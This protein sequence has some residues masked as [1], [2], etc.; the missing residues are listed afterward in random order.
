MGFCMHT[1]MRLA[2][3]VVCGVCYIREHQR[4]TQQE[5]IASNIDNSRKR[6]RARWTWWARYK[7]PSSFIVL[8]DPTHRSSGS[9]NAFPCAGWRGRWSN[10]DSWMSNRRPFVFQSVT[11]TVAVSQGGQP[12][13]PSLVLYG[14]LPRF[15]LSQNRPRSGSDVPRSTGL[16]I[17]CSTA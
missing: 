9:R 5:K 13:P 7:C 2:L 11:P 1:H 14:R 3:Y 12:C 10:N 8:S 16:G 15:S 4:G 6:W 17:E